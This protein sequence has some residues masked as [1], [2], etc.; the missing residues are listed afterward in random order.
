MALGA[1]P[2]N[3]TWADAEPHCTSNVT[4]SSVDESDPVLSKRE[5]LLHVARA[6]RSADDPVIRFSPPVS[7]ETS[8]W[9][10][11]TPDRTGEQRMLIWESDGYD[12]EADRILIGLTA[13]AAAVQA[14]L[15]VQALSAFPVFASGSMLGSNEGTVLAEQIRTG[16][17]ELQLDLSCDQFV[18]PKELKERR[19]Q[20]LGL[21]PGTAMTGDEFERLIDSGNVTIADID[22]MVN[23]RTI[24]PN[25]LIKGI[26]ARET[27]TSG[28][29]S[30]AQP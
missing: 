27:S 18:D 19:R 17:L 13:P 9:A 21:P 6:G 20:E 3:A 10:S 7:P 11:Q 28:W 5:V 24:S 30:L 4:M 16:G 15:Q 23:S 8:D 1:L 25:M 2:L 14:T 22:T 29:N 12:D 26:Q